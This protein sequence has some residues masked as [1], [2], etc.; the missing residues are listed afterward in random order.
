MNAMRACVLAAFGVATLTGCTTARTLSVSQ[1]NRTTR[2]NGK[3]NGERKHWLLSV[4]KNTAAV[5]LL[6]PACSIRLED[7]S[8]PAFLVA[9]RNGGD[10]TI[11]LS[12]DDVTATVDGRP[13]HIL[14]YEEY[15]AA[16]HDQEVWEWARARWASDGPVSGKVAPPPLEQRAYP[17]EGYCYT[18]STDTNDFVIP[19]SVSTIIARTPDDALLDVRSM[20]VLGQYSIAPGQTVSGV[21]RFKP[22]ELSRGQRLRILVRAGDEMHEFVYDVGH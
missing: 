18:P 10:Q 15:C 22:S 12:R 5:C 20:P 21:V 17:P 2:A 4:K 1:E 19:V 13:I 14:T 11:S 16:I 8:P 6:T 7:L 3:V 9:I